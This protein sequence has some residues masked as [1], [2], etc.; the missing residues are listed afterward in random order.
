[1]QESCY[2]R[3]S[4]KGTV[5]DDDGRMLLAREGDAWELLGGGLDHG[6]A[7]LEGLKREV[8][9][10]TGLT[11]TSV[12][13]TPRYFVTWQKSSGPWGANVIYQMELADL[14]FTPSE[15]CQE[16]RFFTVE[17][18]GRVKLHPNVQKLY[19]LLTK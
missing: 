10:E 9:E 1:M 13:D 14:N 19:E 17:E 16:L 12:S 15:E 2:Y 7:P 18:M 6:E 11:V 3:V 8:H 5:I 4:I